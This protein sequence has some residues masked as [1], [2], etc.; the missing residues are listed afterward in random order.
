MRKREKKF[1]SKHGSSPT[2]QL[3]Q[4]L[5]PLFLPLHWLLTNMEPN[6]MFLPFPL[7]FPQNCVKLV[8]DCVYC[9]LNLQAF[10]Q[11]LYFPRSME[12]PTQRMCCAHKEMALS[13]LLIHGGITLCE[14]VGF[15]PTYHSQ[16][17]QYLY[18]LDIETWLPQWQMGKGRCYHYRNTSQEVLQRSDWIEQ[19]AL[20][21]TLLS[22]RK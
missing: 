17:Q 10:N 20:V 3:T 21:L 14:P 2:Q 6:Q 7:R 5:K 13:Q 9:S 4:Q 8:G 12:L 16:F 1:N 19:P 22:G 18:F 11:T 15:I